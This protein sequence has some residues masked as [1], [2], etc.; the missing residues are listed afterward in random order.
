[1]VH[2]KGTL[3]RM[4]VTE[5]QD[6]VAQMERQK[7]DLEIKISKVVGHN[8]KLSQKITVQNQKNPDN[9]QQ[10]KRQPRNVTIQTPDDEGEKTR[11]KS[12]G[13]RQ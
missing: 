11:P 9:K 4:S 13:A 1:M 2:K 8:K 10:A 6:L 5:L 3:S 12:T 7:K